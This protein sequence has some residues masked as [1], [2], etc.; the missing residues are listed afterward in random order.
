MV[1]A[2][3]GSS[4][5]PRFG[6]GRT[7]ATRGALAAIRAGGHSPAEFLRRHHHGDWGD[8]SAH[9][10]RANEAA[11]RDGSRIISVYQTSQRQTLWVITEAAGDDGQRASTCL[12]LPEEY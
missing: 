7:L 2:N 9:D 5:T 3:N 11:L 8:V 12:M 10:R 4:L 1:T 6:L